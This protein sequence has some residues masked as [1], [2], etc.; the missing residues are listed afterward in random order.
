MTFDISHPD[1]L[2]GQVGNPLLAV[3]ETAKR[4]F[5]TGAQDTILPHGRKL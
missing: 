2:V 4:R 3:D 5:A 1:T